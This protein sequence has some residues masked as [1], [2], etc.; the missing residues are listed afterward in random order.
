MNV[1]NFVYSLVY[2]LISEMSFNKIDLVYLTILQDLTNESKSLSEALVIVCRLNGS[3]SFQTNIKASSDALL[4]KIKNT[5]G[6]YIRSY[7]SIKSFSL[8]SLFRF[9]NTLLVDNS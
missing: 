2:F 9:F 7:F 8:S 5:F 6:S 3:T 1:K 4:N